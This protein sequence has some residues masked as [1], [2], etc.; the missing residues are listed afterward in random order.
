MK[1]LVVSSSTLFGFAAATED[2]YPA[3]PSLEVVSDISSVEVFPDILIDHDAMYS[4]VEE[5]TVPH[6]SP[7]K[8]AGKA[9]LLPSF[10]RTLQEKTGIFAAVDSSHV[11]N[12]RLMTESSALHIDE[13]QNGRQGSPGRVGFV[14]LNT[15]PDAHFN[16][17][18]S[19]VPVVE[20]RMVL[21]DGGIPHNTIVNA[22]SVKLLGPFEVKSFIGVGTTV[23]DSSFD[24]C[25]LAD[26][27]CGCT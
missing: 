27:S 12:L 1:F 24:T 6:H 16:H 22:G 7:G 19:S 18:Q 5:P 10:F 25:D 21:F 11:T 20:G 8:F 15:N 14:F 4:T 13:Y 23:C 26:A 3:S 2:A 17:G 9:R